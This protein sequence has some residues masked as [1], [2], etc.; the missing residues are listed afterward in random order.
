MIRKSLY[1]R[2][3]ERKYFFTR[4][5]KEG[6]NRLGDKMAK[7]TNSI[8]EYIIDLLETSNGMVEIQRAILAEHFS[9]APS[10][11]NYVLTTRFTPYKGYYVESRRG[12]GGYIRIVEVDMTDDYSLYTREIGE[13]LT[14][15]R[16]KDF[17]S[18]LLKQGKITN[19]EAKIL[20]LALSDKTL[21]DVEEKNKLR[22]KIL[23]M[24]LVGILD[25]EV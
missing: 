24:V 17:I 20:S 14:A 11:I 25:K 1:A 16:A 22:A 13:D 9:C 21:G 5:G 15:L 7:L 3:E 18:S 19:R 4:K 23:K 2:I 6:Q 12:G 8:E 10:Q